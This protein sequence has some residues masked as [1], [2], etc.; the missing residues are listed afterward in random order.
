MLSGLNQQH[1]YSDTVPA[2][3][4]SSFYSVYSFCKIFILVSSL[5][6][7]FL[8]RLIRENPVNYR[9]IF[10]EWYLACFPTP[11]TSIFIRSANIT[12][13][14]T[15]IATA[16]RAQL[17]RRLFSS[18]NPLSVSRL[19]SDFSFSLAMASKFLPP[20]FICYAFFSSIIIRKAY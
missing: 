18:S 4:P 12:S 20:K 14:I 2:G 7:Y 19:S 16:R 9:Y 10:K 15:I 17:S 11:P 6:H 8:I 13:H 1:H 5:F 3:L